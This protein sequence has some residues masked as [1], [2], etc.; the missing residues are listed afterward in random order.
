MFFRGKPYFSSNSLVQTFKFD[1][2]PHQRTNT[3]LTCHPGKIDPND[4]ANKSWPPDPERLYYSPYSPSSGILAMDSAHGEAWKWKQ[5]RWYVDMRG[6]V[7]EEG[8]EYALYWNGRYWWCGGNWHGKAVW[9]H[10]WVRRRRWVRD[11]ERIEHQET[12]AQPTV[13]R[14][15]GIEGLLSRLRQP[16]SPNLK[17]RV[18][19]EFFD[20]CLDESIISLPSSIHRIYILLDPISTFTLLRLIQQQ[21]ERCQDSG[22]EDCL[23]ALDASLSFLRS[24]SSIRPE[25]VSTLQSLN[26]SDWRKKEETHDHPSRRTRLRKLRAEWIKTRQSAALLIR[27]V[28]F[29]VKDPESPE[30]EFVTAPESMPSAS[31]TSSSESREEW[32]VAPEVQGDVL[33]RAKSVG[34]LLKD[35]K[36]DASDSGARDGKLVD[37]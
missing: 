25:K 30:E 11:M 16:Q 20:A 6:D 19:Q 21:I 27:K 29:A 22:K 10:G 35:N 17:G 9:F 13:E 5:D 31:R 2:P 1:P 7:D 4:P 14:T 18:L 33:E 28:R 3:F 24:R 26:E 12:P 15:G 32:F 34:G 8:W 36:E 37:T 23:V